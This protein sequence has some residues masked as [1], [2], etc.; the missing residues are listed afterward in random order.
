MK[1]LEIDIKNIEYTTEMRCSKQELADLFLSVNWN[2][3][4]YPDRLYKA[5]CGSTYKVFAY[6]KEKLVGM[7]SGLADGEINF[8]I[9]YI[10]VRPEYQRKK[11]GSTLLQKIMTIKHYSRVVLISEEDIKEFYFYNHF[12]QDGV[13]MFRIDW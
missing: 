9:S 11:I 13:G 8:I 10:L 2:S 5:I 3:G 12:I 4:K 1:K 6:D 7:V